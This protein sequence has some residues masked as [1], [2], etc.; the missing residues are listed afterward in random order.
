MMILQRLDDVV[1]T[2]AI[3]ELPLLVE[4]TSQLASKDL[5]L[6]DSA[7]GWALLLGGEPAHS[8]I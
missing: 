8:T 2:R 3:H 4:T 7:V 5:C 6:M 1:S